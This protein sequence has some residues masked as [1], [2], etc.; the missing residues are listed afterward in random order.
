MILTLPKI[1]GFRAANPGFSRALESAGL[2]QVCP[3]KA[4]VGRQLQA[5]IHRLAF[6]RQH[7]EHTLVNA[8]ERF[9]RDEAFQRLHS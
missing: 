6:E 1:C 3:A 5:W 2:S 4:A 7:T 9:A 8:P